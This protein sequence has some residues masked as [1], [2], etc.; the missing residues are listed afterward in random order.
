MPCYQRLCSTDR[1]AQLRLALRTSSW[2]YLRPDVHP[3]APAV[4]SSTAAPAALPTPGFQWDA[5]RCTACP[6][7]P[8]CD[9]WHRATE[10]Y[11]LTR[12]RTAALREAAAR[13]RNSTCPAHSSLAAVFDDV[14]TMRNT[15]A[16]RT[17]I[18]MATLGATLNESAAAAHCGFS[19]TWGECL[20]EPGRH[21]S[22][23]QQRKGVA[24]FI[25]FPS[26]ASFAVA[27]AHPSQFIPFNLGPAS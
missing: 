1:A 22:S 9:V 24:P 27:V 5:T 23:V 15:L 17:F 26:F 10:C 7:A 19:T 16:G 18:F 20:A 12:R 6:G 3:L 21:D 4:S 11:L 14:Y 8:S 2:R 25:T 13:A